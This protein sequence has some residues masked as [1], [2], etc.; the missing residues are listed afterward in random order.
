MEQPRIYVDDDGHGDPTIW[1]EVAP[2]ASQGV[3]SYSGLAGSAAVRDAVWARLV[4]GIAATETSTP[5]YA[6]GYADGY[7][8]ADNGIEAER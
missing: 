1:C 4:A 6:T 5:E 7:A 2:G 3:V 8:D